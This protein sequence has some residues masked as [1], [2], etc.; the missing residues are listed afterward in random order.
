MMKKIGEGFFSVCCGGHCID[1]DAF[2]D[3][4][5]QSSIV[6]VGCV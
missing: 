2:A 6:E 1:G 4:D 3:N 5:L